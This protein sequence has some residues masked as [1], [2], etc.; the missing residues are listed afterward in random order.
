MIALKFISSSSLPRCNFKNHIQDY[1]LTFPATSVRFLLQCSILSRIYRPTLVSFYYI[2]FLFYRAKFS[3]QLINNPARNNATR[4]NHSTFLFSWDV[5]FT[6]RFLLTVPFLFI[7]HFFL[8]SSC[9]L[10]AIN[11]VYNYLLDVTSSPVLKSI[12]RR[13]DHSSNLN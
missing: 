6:T 1:T 3:F 2:F 10:Q 5:P 4:A 8:L 9:R 13:Q 7:F 11:F 12:R